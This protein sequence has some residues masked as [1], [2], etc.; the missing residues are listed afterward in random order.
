MKKGR[1]FSYHLAN[2]LPV[3]GLI[4]RR[5]TGTVV[6]LCIEVSPACCSGAKGFRVKRCGRDSEKAQGNAVHFLGDGDEFARA[7]Q[8]EI[9]RLVVGCP[10]FVCLK[11]IDVLIAIFVAGAEILLVD[12]IAQLAGYLQEV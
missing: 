3:Q 1:V 10:Q 4:Y 6:E 8:P 11:V 7:H 2:R 9:D 12:V 5:P